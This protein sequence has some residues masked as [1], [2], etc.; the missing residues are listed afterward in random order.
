MASGVIFATIEDETG[1]GNIIIWPKVFQRYRRAALTS[2][3]LCV[4]DKI[5][6]EGLVIHL[7]A[8]R[9]ED[10]SQMLSTLS[11]ISATDAFTDTLAHADEVK[12]PGHDQRLVLPPPAGISDEPS[13]PDKF[14]LSAKCEFYIMLPWQRA[15]LHCLAPKARFPLLHKC[16]THLFALFTHGKDDI[17]PI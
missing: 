7:I 4:T 14:A 1:I 16:I 11:S 13:K 8:D 5:Q 3:L 9:L 17:W 10:Y 6:R 2:T 12:R 15:A